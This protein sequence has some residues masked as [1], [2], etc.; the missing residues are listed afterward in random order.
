MLL[1]SVMFVEMFGGMRVDD[2]KDIVIIFCLCSVQVMLVVSFHSENIAEQRYCFGYNWVLLRPGPVAEADTGFRQSQASLIWQELEEEAEGQQG[3]SYWGLF[4]PRLQPRR[5]RTRLE[6]EDDR[7]GGLTWRRQ[8]R[9]S[10]HSDDDRIKYFL[11]G[12]MAA[13]FALL[14]NIICPLIYKSHWG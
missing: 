3:A 10:D 13:V 2:L 14:L 4:R 1:K 6:E 8:E 5:P 7:H 12:T 11:L 9:V